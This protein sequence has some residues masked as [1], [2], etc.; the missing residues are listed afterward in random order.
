[1]AYYSRPDEELTCQA[2][3]V[4]ASAEDPEYPATNL[5][6]EHGANPAKLTTLDGDF[7]FEFSGAVSPQG[8]APIYHYLDPGLDVRIQGNSSD[9]WGSPPYERS[10]T[11]PAKRKDGPSYQRWT[12]NPFRLL[13]S[14]PSYAFWRLWIAAPNSQPVAIGRLW[15]AEGLHRVTLF[16]EGDM[17]ESDRPDDDLGQIVHPT[18]LGVETVYTIGG[19]RRGL[20]FALIGTDLDAGTAP[21]QE[22]SDF[23]DLIESSDGRAHPWLLVPFETGDD[24]RLVKPDSPA[25]QRSHRVGG[26]QV[27]PYSVREVSRGLPWP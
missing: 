4:T 27:W 12:N 7:V 22:A 6:E 25:G 2:V 14:D 24:A 10:I 9:S 8:V 11:I 21:V 26:Y 19:P 15:L 17:G 23:R 20:S 16:H 3:A 5:L 1:M 13:D 18:Q